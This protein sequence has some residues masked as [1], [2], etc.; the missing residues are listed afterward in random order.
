[1]T[2]L[3]AKLTRPRIVNSHPLPMPPMMGEVTRDPTQEKM[4]RMKLLR[5]TPSEDFFGMNSV[6]MV[7]TMLKMSMEP[8][9]KKKLATIYRMRL[10]KRTKRLEV[11]IHTGTSQNT[12]FS[13]VQPYQISAAGYKKAPSQAF[14][15]M[16][17]SGRKIN[18]P[19]SSNRFAFFASRCM[20]LSI[21][22][23]PKILATI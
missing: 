5:A 15:R 4:F 14:S 23:P 2:A 8:I 3:L 20:M 7:V 13:A 16:R 6:S 17:S 12:P 11:W 19:F 10:V 1:M 18:L 21:H 22:L 9:P